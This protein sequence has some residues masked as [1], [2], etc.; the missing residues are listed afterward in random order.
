MILFV[1]HHEPNPRASRINYFVY[2]FAPFKRNQSA[3]PIY[4]NDDPV[5]IANDTTDC[6]E[7]YDD[8]IT[9]PFLYGFDEEDDRSFANQDALP[10]GRDIVTIGHEDDDEDLY[11][12]PERLTIK[13]CFNDVAR[14]VHKWNRDYG[15][16]NTLA[17]T[18]I[19]TNDG[20]ERLM[21]PTPSSTD[22]HLDL[23][24]YPKPWDNNPVPAEVLQLYPRS[25]HEDIVNEPQNEDDWSIVDVPVDENAEEPWGQMP[26]WRHIPGGFYAWMQRPGH[27]TPEDGR[28]R[29]NVPEHEGSVSSMDCLV[30]RAHR[31]IRD[32]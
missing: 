6:L 28:D 1:A 12:S 32:T 5:D 3:L 29:E 14:V 20:D 11:T 8:L 25:R 2:F 4:F 24:L 9:V 30:T 22:E 15:P 27:F 23:V 17:T 10:C 7:I 18:S 26:P 19:H 31:Y 21:Y 16:L 13:P